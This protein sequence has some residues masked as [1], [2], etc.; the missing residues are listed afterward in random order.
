ML[1]TPAAE[2]GVATVGGL[3]VNAACVFE[4]QVTPPSTTI[5]VLL[6]GGR[7]YRATAAYEYC[8][9]VERFARTA[10]DRIPT[11]PLLTIAALPNRCE[12]TVMKH[13]PIRAALWRS[14]LGIV[15]L[16]SV[17]L[18]G[19]SSSSNTTAVQSSSSSPAASAATSAR[20]AVLSVG[21]LDERA[22]GR[23]TIQ[24][25]RRCMPPCVI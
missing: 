10:I 9:T 18:A 8:D 1:A 22:K 13:V 23:R 4:P 3:G 5:L 24:R 21:S 16:A 12:G 15:A 7:I 25:V 2:P 11:W 6:D 20:P 14:Q 17:L 19:C